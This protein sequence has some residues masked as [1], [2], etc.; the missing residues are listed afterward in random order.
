MARFANLLVAA[1]I[2]LG[3]SGAGVQAQ[4]EDYPSRP[5]RMIVA[6]PA[7]GVIDLLS[8]I[9]ADAL[10][11]ELNQTIVVE[12]R[13]GGDGTIG[14]MEVVRSEPDGYTILSDGFGG[15]L[16]PPLMKSNFPVDVQNDLTFIARPAEFA[17]VVVIN[18]D[19]PVN[20]VDELIA[21]AKEHPGEL[22]VAASGTAT[23]DRLTA[24][25]FMQATG[26]KF[27][28]VPYK[29]AAAALQD[30][31]AGV[32]Q[33]MFAN[34]PP[35]LGLIQ[36]GSI[37]ALAVTSTYRMSQLPDV[38]TLDEAGVK[39][40]AMTSWNGIFGPKA[41]PQEIVDR[42]NAAYVK[43]SQSPEVRKKLGKI[44]YEPVSQT[45]AEFRAFYDEERDRWKTVIDSAGLRQ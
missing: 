10:G 11:K 28:L 23:S 37:K 19:L 16:I 26:T 25:M 40:F 13:F 3:L 24:E 14:L 34:M 2:A 7:G 15:E 8:R 38:P 1:A 12:N 27:T 36:A 21:Y 45:A 17:N 6:Y 39:G 41:L 29:G 22:N 35:A 31:T 4:S 43:T 42:L 33:V 18:K 30:M 32:I 44:G 9:Y 20:S 5:I